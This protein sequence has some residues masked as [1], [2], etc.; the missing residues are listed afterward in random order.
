VLQAKGLVAGYR[1]TPVLR[2]VDV[3]V[4]PGQAVA[5]LGPNGAG[6]STLFKAMIG[7]LDL[8]EGEIL[9]DEKRVT[10]LAAHTRVRHGLAYLPQVERVFPS[11]NLT[12]NLRMGAYTMTGDI[13]ARMEQVLSLFPDLAEDVKKRGGALSGGQQTM[14]GMARALMVDPKYLLLD[15]PTAGLSPLYM[16]RVWERIRAVR[17]TGIGVLVIEQNVAL[18]LQHADYAYVLVD[19]QN[20]A[21]DRADQLINRSDIEGLFVG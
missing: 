19:G 16:K 10:H 2:G 11:L 21:Y 8:D 20:A 17:D 18:A 6:K 3:E 15:E 5:V 12:E 9:I 7:L 1:E 4:Q 13:R 14:L